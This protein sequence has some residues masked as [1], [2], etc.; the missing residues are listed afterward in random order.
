[1]LASM[2]RSGYRHEAKVKDDAALASLLRQYSKDAPT[3]GYRFAW[4]H[5]RRLGWSVNHKRVHRVWRDCGLSQPRRRKRLRRGPKTVVPVKAAFK[6]H[7]WCYDF[8]EDVTVRGTKLRFLTVEDEFTREGLAVSVGFSMPAVRVIEVLE[9][10]FAAHGACAYVRS[11]NGPEFIA[12][13]LRRMLEGQGVRTQYIDPGKPWQNG[14]GERFNGSLRCEC[15][16]RDEFHGLLDAQ[17]KV[18]SW[19][20]HYNV[21]RPHSSL[22]YLTP[23]EFAQGIAVPELARGRPSSSCAPPR[24]QGSLMACGA[25]DEERGG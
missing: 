14:K 10:L 17:T 15:L 13:A 2:S 4:V 7:V 8:V 11:D 22:G 20:T 6:G 3:S 19:R 21:D 18:E 23:A 9:R 5:V 12:F 25:Q 24:S 16:N 1:M